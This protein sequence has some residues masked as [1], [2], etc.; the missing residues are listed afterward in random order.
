MSA[1]QIIQQKPRKE[2]KA[3]AD[4]RRQQLLDAT[5]RSI[6]I[7]G[8]S[9]TTLA[10]VANEAGLSQGVVV[11]YFKSKT[12][13]LTEALK[14]QYARYQD[15]WTKALAKAGSEPLDQL[16]ALIEADFAPSIC[17]TE[18]LSI[19]FAFW[20]EQKFTPQYAEV[21][22][23][24]DQKRG[25][26]IRNVCHQLLDNAADSDIDKIAGWIDILTDGYWQKLHVFPKSM[27]RKEAVAE[28]LDFV[29][30]LLPEY[31]DRISKRI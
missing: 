18:A 30:K 6:M 24:F 27:R 26:A 17:N 31:E 4:K 9:K 12:G 5:L 29:S 16:I 21:S 28:T 8:L 19:W 10:T 1:Q 7:N 3:N 23:A 22:A 20:G 25:D 15:N 13:L 2:R 14:E 11:F